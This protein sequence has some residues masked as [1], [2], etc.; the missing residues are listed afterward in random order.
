MQ[1]IRGQE[2][3]LTQQFIDAIMPLFREYREMDTQGLY[4][5]LQLHAPELCSN[6]GMDRTYSVWQ[7]DARKALD[8]LK[9]QQKIEL[10]PKPGYERKGTYRLVGG[11]SET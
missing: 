6:R 3:S 1:S 2:K 7:R 9:E 8:R 5:H 4:A 11:Y 10:V